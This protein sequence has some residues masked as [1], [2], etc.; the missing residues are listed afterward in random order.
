[1]PLAIDLLRHGDTGFAGF[2][3]TLDDPLTPQ[4]WQQMEQAVAG[5]VW[6]VVV[7]SPRLRCASFAQDYSRRQAMPLEID[8]RLVELDF[9][10][11][12][13]KTAEELMKSDAAALQD[14]WQ[15]PERH[16][17]PDGESM[18]NFSARVLQAWRDI[19]L[20]HHG[21][22]VLLISHGGVIRRLLC[23]ARGLPLK[24]LL[25]L[26]VAHGTLHSLDREAV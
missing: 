23:H 12:E 10:L 18:A 16:P 13:G 15:D 5:K 24:Q 7:S 3:G 20:E 19:G 6:D 4:G 8:A 22:R 1:M 2:R 14:F 25:T 11:W 26:D 21:Q 9:G 17:P